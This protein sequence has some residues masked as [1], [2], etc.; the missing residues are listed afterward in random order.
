MTTI[1]HAGGPRITRASSEAAP[2]APAPTIP[3]FMI[4]PR[5]LAAQSLYGAPAPTGHRQL[6]RG[7]VD[8]NFPLVNRRGLRSDAGSPAA[9]HGRRL[10]KPGA[11][12]VCPRALPDAA[13]AQW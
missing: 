10:A 13:V 1:W 5:L 6:R 4:C 2:T 12:R 9:G 3:T 8:R 7:R 11:P